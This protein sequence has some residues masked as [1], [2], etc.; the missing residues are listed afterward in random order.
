MISENLSHD[1]SAVNFFN[2]KLI[3]KSKQKFSEEN[4]KQIKYFYIQKQI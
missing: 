2:H 3:A 4:V 1:A